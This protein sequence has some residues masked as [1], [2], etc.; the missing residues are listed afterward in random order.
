LLSVYGNS[1]RMA[2][3]FVVVIVLAVIGVGVMQSLKVLERNT[4]RW[5]YDEHS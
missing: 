5:R 2:P 1:F 3:Y 4:A